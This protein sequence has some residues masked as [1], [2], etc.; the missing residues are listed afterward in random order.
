MVTGFN[1]FQ[2][3]SDTIFS[4]QSEIFELQ[5]K[6]QVTIEVTPTEIPPPRTGTN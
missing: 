5:Q 6:R 1:L 3:P 2:L 4:Y